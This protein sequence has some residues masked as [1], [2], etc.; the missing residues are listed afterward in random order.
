MLC[1]A[2]CYTCFLSE[3]KGCLPLFTSSAHSVYFYTLYR[4]HKAHKTSM[5]TNVVV[6]TI[7]TCTGGKRRQ[8]DVRLSSSQPQQKLPQ[9]VYIYVYSFGR[10]RCSLSKTCIYIICKN[11]CWYFCY[12]DKAGLWCF[13]VWHRRHNN[14]HGEKQPENL[15][16][17]KNSFNSVLFTQ[18]QITTSVASMCFIL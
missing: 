2:S 12:L 10:C 4:S 14:H 16:F 9:S 1:Y 17:F 18:Y 8:M 11:A 6:S 7:M 13:T 5:T 15:H 3:D